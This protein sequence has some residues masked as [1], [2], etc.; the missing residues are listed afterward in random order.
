MVGAR[1]SSLTRNPRQTLGR[2]GEALAAEYLQERGYQLLERNFRSSYGEI[3]LIARL[4][5]EA[6][7][8]SESVLVFV[9]VKTRASQAYGFP[10]E[11]VTPAK[12]AHLIQSAQAYLQTHP[13]QEG[14]WRIDVIA[15]RI[16]QPDGA[17]EIKHIE[18]A[19]H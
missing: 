19:V 18:N 2:R 4:Q 11:S 17:V 1:K 9:E 3:D 5:G 16:V 12:Q 15:V 8:C 7:P 14:N 6:G 13:E 10:E